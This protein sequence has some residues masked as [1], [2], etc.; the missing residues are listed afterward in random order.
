MWDISGQESLLSSWNTYYTS[1]VSNSCCGQYRPRSSLIGKLSKMRAH[2]NLRKT[3]LLIFANNQDVK[4]CIRHL[5]VF[6][7]NFS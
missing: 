6:E 3:G 4:E 2:E 1:R 5:P 7:T